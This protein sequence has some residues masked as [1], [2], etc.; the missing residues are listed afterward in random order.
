LPL[1]T[2]IRGAGLLRERPLLIETLK[3]VAAGRIDPT[4]SGDV[5]DLTAEVE[6]AVSG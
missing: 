6:R 1:F 5:V 2:A 3:A 4:G